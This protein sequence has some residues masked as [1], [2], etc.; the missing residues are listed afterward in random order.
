METL[1]NGKSLDN[2]K[3]RGGD[4]GLLVIGY[5]LWGEMN[6]YGLWRTRFE[7]STHFSVISVLSV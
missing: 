3:L 1:A 6:G 7:L 4:E 2:R 5:W